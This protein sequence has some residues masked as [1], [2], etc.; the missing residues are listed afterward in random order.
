MGSGQEMDERKRQTEKTVEGLQHFRHVFHHV[1]A[2]KSSMKGFDLLTFCPWP[3]I[4]RGEARAGRGCDVG[5]C[6]MHN[7]QPDSACAPVR[8]L[9]GTG[10]LPSQYNRPQHGHAMR[11]NKFCAGCWITRAA[12]TPGLGLAAFAFSTV[13]LRTNSHSLTQLVL[14][15]G[16]SRN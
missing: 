16:T 2:L 8:L 9:I 12:P 13:S 11:T 10:L 1:L 5:S 4:A 3:G 15:Q 7:S 14:L 6:W